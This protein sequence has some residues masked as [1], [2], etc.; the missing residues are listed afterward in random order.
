MADLLMPSSPCSRL[1]G[2]AHAQL[3]KQENRD[4]IQVEMQTDVEVPVL[5]SFQHNELSVPEEH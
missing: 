5:K 4:S 2:A 3:S 1:R